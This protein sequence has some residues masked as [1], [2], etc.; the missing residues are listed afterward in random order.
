M[1]ERSELR[2]GC[3][4]LLRNLRLEMGYSKS[5][6]AECVGVDYRTWDNYEAGIASPRVDEFIHY[7][8]IF[9][10]DALRCVLNFL[11]PEV[12]DSLTPES[13]A[14]DLRQAC[15]HYVSTVASE[16][17]IR[18]MDFLI[19]GEHGSCVF[20]QSEMFVMLNHL[21][22]AMRMIV[23][24]MVSSLYYIAVTNELLVNT[25]RIMPCIDIFEQGRIKSKQAIAN[26][27]TSYT[28]AT[29]G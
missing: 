29:R 9:S 21:P 4:T 12:Y 10:A 22:L 18:K 24:D 14:D 7:F 28:T 26:G 19:F 6:M 23:A 13:N 15:V 1:R 17:A 5:K 27:K 3:A 25:D 8:D 2:M 11:Y 20:A 16:H